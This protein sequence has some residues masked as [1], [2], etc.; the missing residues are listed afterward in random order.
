MMAGNTKA[1]AR[2]GARVG[3]QIR[4]GLWCGAGGQFVSGPA[5]AEELGVDLELLNALD[6][7]LKMDPIDETPADYKV[8][9][10][11]VA[12]LQKMGPVDEKG[13][14][15]DNAKALIA[16]LI[17][18]DTGRALSIMRRASAGKSVGGF[19][20]LGDS[21]WIGFFSNVFFDRDVRPDAPKG[22]RFTL[23][24]L[25]E[26]AEWAAAD[27]ANMPKLLFW[28]LPT[29]EIGTATH[30]EVATPFIVA[31]GEWADNENGKRARAYFD[32]GGEWAMSHGFRYRPEDRENGVYKRFRT[33]EVSVLPR[34]WA[35][36]PITLF[37]KE[38]GMKNGLGDLVKALASM[39]GISEDEAQEMASQGLAQSKALAEESGEIVVHKDADADPAEEPQPGE[40]DG[41]A[42][43]DETV[44]DDELALALADAL[45]EVRDGKEKRAK[46]EAELKAMK[47][48]IETTTKRL[49]TLEKDAEARKALLPRAVQEALSS[50]RNARDGEV[51]K[52]KDVDADQAAQA[53][54][55]KAGRA[56]D[57]GRDPMGWM[58]HQAISIRN[59]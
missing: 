14:P 27:T 58:L 10:E 6:N 24:A 42:D 18:G 48:L 41:G 26:Y 31:K 17:A 53:D 12:E 11:Q 4:G 21:G 57:A 3:E 25:K 33:N 22:E 47:S 13:I 2:W 39:L 7:L 8:T 30:I 50:V 44:T 49:D 20:S 52:E 46:L 29:V 15:N 1:E 37:W 59:E 40:A 55:L 28:H 16:A 5:I 35:A 19:K 32:Q 38:L 34:E 36:N 9:D 56:P 51:V 45:I 43:G 23:D 54:A